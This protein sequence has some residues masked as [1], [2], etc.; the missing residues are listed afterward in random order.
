[1]EPA[2]NPDRKLEKLIKYLPIF[3]ISHALVTVP[4]FVISVALAYAT[5]VQADATRKIQTSETW[6][7]VSYETSNTNDAG[8][9]IIS[10]ILTNDGVGPARLKALEFKYA[11]HTLKNPRQ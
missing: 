8:E 7:M 11:E 3:M 6:P 1:M 2:P 9:D 5:F 4:T 10:F